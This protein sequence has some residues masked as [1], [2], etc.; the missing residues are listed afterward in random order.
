MTAKAYYPRARLLLAVIL[1]ATGCASVNDMTM[2]LLASGVTVYAVVGDHVLS[3]EATLYTDRSGTLTLAGKTGDD[4]NCVGSMRYTSSTGGTIQLRC[5]DD[6]QTTLAFTALTE[7]S[8]HARAL[9]GHASL[10]Y[11]LAAESARAW[12]IAPA[13]KRLVVSGGSLRLE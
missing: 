1:L 3:G 12:L 8:G 10:T 7:T 13:G 4:A 2:K 9:P 5:S 11:G 6:L